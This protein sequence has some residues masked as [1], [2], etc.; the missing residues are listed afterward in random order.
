[1]YPNMLSMDCTEERKNSGILT[2]ISSDKEHNM[3]SRNLHRLFL[4]IDK[5]SG[6]TSLDMT[7]LVLLTLKLFEIAVFG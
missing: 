6:N 3:I 4:K 7:L 2:V 5:S 1:M